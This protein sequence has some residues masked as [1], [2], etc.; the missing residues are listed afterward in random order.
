MNKITIKSTS[1]DP[2]WRDAR[3]Y[4][5]DP[6]HFDTYEAKIFDGNAIIFGRAE[7]MP[8]NQYSEG[9]WKN[10]YRTNMGKFS[11]G[12]VLEWRQNLQMEFLDH[13]E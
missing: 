7:W 4:Q 9:E 6:S 12:I 5:P 13:S 8:K 10:C 11:D 1:T 3:I 2:K